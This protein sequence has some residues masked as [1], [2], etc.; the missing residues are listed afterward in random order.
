MKSGPLPRGGGRMWPPSHDRIK[1]VGNWC[2]RA[3]EPDSESGPGVAANPRLCPGARGADC[4]FCRRLP[5]RCCGKERFMQPLYPH[6][7]GL[8]VHKDSVFAC[9]RHLGDDGKARETIR[10]FATTTRG[11]LALGDW[12]VT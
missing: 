4:S 9:V 12:L 11:L 7:G 8:D 6:C 2:R 1:A 5:D 10:S 3:A